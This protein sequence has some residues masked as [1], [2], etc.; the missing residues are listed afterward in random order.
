MGWRLNSRIWR[1]RAMRVAKAITLT[2]EERVALT[3][4]ARGR[5][6]PVRLVQRAKIIL[7]AANG[8]ENKDIAVELGCT[9]RTVGTWRN[10]FVAARLAG[11]ER[12][13][14]RRPHADATAE[15]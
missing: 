14:A 5:S 11:I 10:R 13:A 15:V 3:K 1:I 7:A 12:C 9:R 8:R 4:W 6:T 2:D